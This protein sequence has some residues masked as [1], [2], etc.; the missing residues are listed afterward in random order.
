MVDQPL[1]LKYRPLAFGEVIGHASVLDALQRAMSSSSHPHSYLLTGPAGLGKTTLARII[2][3]H[4]KAE[5]HEINGSSSN[6]IDDIRALIELGDHAGFGET[7]AR[8]FIIDECHGLSKPAFNAILKM[9]EEPPSHL[10]IMLCTTELSKIIETI[11]TRCYHV[12]L[13]SLAVGEMQELL[14]I[15][16]D[17]EG[18]KVAPDV[19]QAVVQAATGQP[20]KALSMLQVVHDAPNREEVRRIIQLQEMADPT[21]KLMQAVVSG[22][23]SWKTVQDYLKN[24]PD[25]EYEEMSIIAGRYIAAAMI[26]SDHSEKAERLWRVLEAFVYPTQ[27]FDKKVAFI[28]MLGRIVWAGK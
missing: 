3:D 15:V 26:S 16:V 6:S 23:A 2:A 4:F 24:I 5:V 12:Q 11:R 9:L 17:C 19:L 7:G 28:A 22:K 20:R 18:W 14:D 13:K 10:Y 1:I 25:D 21:L 27:T 8:A